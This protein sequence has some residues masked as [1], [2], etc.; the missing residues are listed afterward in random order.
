MYFKKP[1]KEK[2]KDY[3]EISENASGLNKK[4]HQY[5]FIYIYIYMLRYFSAL[6]FCKENY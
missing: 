4:K 6:P 5:F 2:K 3:L 1:S